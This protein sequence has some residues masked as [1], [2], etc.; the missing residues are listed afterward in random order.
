VVCNL[1]GI[2]LHYNYL[3]LLS[4]DSRKYR[5]EPS[6][7][8]MWLEWVARFFASGPWSDPDSAIWYN[9]Q[10]AWFALIVPVSGL[11][12]LTRSVLL[13]TNIPEIA[14]AMIWNLLVSYLMFGIIPSF[15]YITNLGRKALPWLLDI[16]N[17]CAKFP[18]PV[19]IIVGFITRPV[20]M[21]P[22]IS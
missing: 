10:G 13:N 7:G 2:V 19:I 12:Y 1:F 16:L 5:R 15:V 6:P 14:L 18:L 22:C 9:L 8:M 20:S 17:V 4:P 11:V 21:R 3:M